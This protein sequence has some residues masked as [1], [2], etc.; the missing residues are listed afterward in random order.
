VDYTV[1]E[2][3]QNQSLP[4]QTTFPAEL[5]RSLARTPRLISVPFSQYPLFVGLTADQNIPECTVMNSASGDGGGSFQPVVNF[6][7]A[8][9]RFLHVFA[10]VLGAN[11]VRK[12]GLL[13][14]P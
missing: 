2:S 4:V 12:F 14:E 8:A 10:D 13:D 11:E 9:Q 5:I 3:P 6:L 7:S 1:F